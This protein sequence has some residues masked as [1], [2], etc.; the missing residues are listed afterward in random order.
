[1]SNN[2][3]IGGYFLKVGQ[4]DRLAS[5]RETIIANITHHL[6]INRPIGEQIAFVGRGGN[7]TRLP[8]AKTTATDHCS[9]FLGDS[10]HDDINRWTE[11]RHQMRVT[12]HHKGIDGIDRDPNAIF[13]PIVKHVVADGCSR[14]RALLS[15]IERPLLYTDHTFIRIG[16]NID[17]V[18]VTCQAKDNM[19]SFLRERATITCRGVGVIIGVIAINIERLVVISSES[20]TF[21][22]PRITTRVVVNDERNIGRTIISKRRVEIDRRQSTSCHS[23]TARKHYIVFCWDDPIDSIAEIGPFCVHHINRVIAGLGSA[24]V[25]ES[26]TREVSRCMKTKFS[27]CKNLFREGIV[28]IG[29]A[30]QRF[31]RRRGLADN[32]AIFWHFHKMCNV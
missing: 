10:H 17:S 19:V 26:D 7:G 27:R 13:S 14:G 9:T 31:F 29:I 28:V 32:D 15:I 2:D 18:F 20:A 25:D 23:H 1:M 24:R 21:H 16:G 3:A 12:R 8:N 4:Q 30:G 11:I 5:H 6:I 22:A